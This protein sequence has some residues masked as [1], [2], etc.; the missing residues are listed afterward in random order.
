MK[1]GTRFLIISG[2]AII[3]VGLFFAGIVF[4]YLSATLPQ[5][6]TT[7]DYRPPVTTQFVMK[8]GNE[9]RV[10]AEFFKERRYLVPFEK[11][12][13]IAIQSFLAAEDVHFFEHQGI[14]WIGIARAAVTNFLAGHVVQGGSTITQ[15]VAKSLFLSPERNL[16]RKAKEAILAGRIEKNLNKQQILYLY[17]NQ[18]YLGHGAYGIQAAAKVYYLR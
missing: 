6:I 11:I 17:L 1:M 4:W 14:S 5:I 16:L 18:I 13:K 7:A 8:E 12:P 2:G 15:Q 9:D 3:F 10:I